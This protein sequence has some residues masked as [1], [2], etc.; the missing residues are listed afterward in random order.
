MQALFE[1]IS[2][3]MDIKGLG[4]LLGNQS[5][6]WSFASHLVEFVSSAPKKTMIF[7]RSKRHNFYQ[8]SKRVPYVNKLTPGNFVKTIALW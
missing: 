7:L 2:V 5:R 4:E 6:A 1:A 3:D 8:A